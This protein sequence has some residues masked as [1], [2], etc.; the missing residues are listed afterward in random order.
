MSNGTL[1]NSAVDG[2]VGIDPDVEAQMQADE[3]AW[4][5]EEGTAQ[6]GAARDERGRFTGANDGQ[7]AAD[8]DTDDI[9]EAPEGSAGAE[10]TAEQ[11][12]T[13]KP[14]A[15]AEPEK[16]K[17]AQEQQQQA[18]PQSDWSKDRTRRDTSWKALNEEKAKFQQEREQFEIQRQQLTAQ[19]QA[20][21]TERRDAS[22]FTAAQ[23]SARAAQWQGEAQTLQAQA[24]QADNEGDFRRAEQ[25]QAQAQ[26]RARLAQA[27][28]QRA[29]SLRPGTVTETWKNL[30]NDLP[31]A[32]EFNGEINVEIR[33]VLR[34]NPQL[35][36]DPSGPYRAAVQVGSKVLKATQTE[37]VKART[38][39]AKVD[40]LQKQVADLTQQLN[41][42]RQRTSLPGGGA[43]ISRESVNGSSENW[44]DLP[45]EEMERRIA[46]GRV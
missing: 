32:A 42:L 35:L 1:E 9:E 41:Q 10:A 36:G 13:P 45:L 37:L 18:K 30:M 34:S 4:A 3:A 23:Y 12:E 14:L 43:P 20:R 39:A 7:R 15:T 29:D 22:G 26:E 2:N 28:T 24:M 38:E 25:L 40:G 27:A 16:P 17:P 44:E 33:K 8:T 19:E 11:P 31:E 46:S 5:Q 6:A 21:M